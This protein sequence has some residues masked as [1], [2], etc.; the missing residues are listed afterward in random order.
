MFPK[1]R[2]K[3]SNITNLLSL[4]FLNCGVG[5]SP[6][7][8]VPCHT[9]I[10]WCNM[11]IFI[12]FCDWLTHTKILWFAIVYWTEQCVL[13]SKI[14][15]INSSLLSLLSSTFQNHESIISVHTNLPNF[16]NVLY[17]WTSLWRGKFERHRAWTLTCLKCINQQRNQSLISILWGKMFLQ[18]L[19]PYKSNL[20]LKLIL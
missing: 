19:S 12:K 3:Q 7:P 9:G 18:T 20:R 14:P 2:C 4:H 16:I 15:D 13:I 10:H 5:S 1:D 17:C 11:H 6:G 8:T